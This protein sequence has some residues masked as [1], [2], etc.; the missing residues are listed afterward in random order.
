MHKDATASQSDYYTRFVQLVAGSIFQAVKWEVRTHRAYR[1][2][3]PRTTDQW[4]QHPHS[5]MLVAL[6]ARARHHSEM[7]AATPVAP[8]WPPL[9]EANPLLA[10]DAQPCNNRRTKTPPAVLGDVLPRTND[11]CYV[12]SRVLGGHIHRRLAVSDARR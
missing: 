12:R 3:V 1:V 8:R 6:W 2:I 11:A 9:L 7:V 4:V 10:R 5:I